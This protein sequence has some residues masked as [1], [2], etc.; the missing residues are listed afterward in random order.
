MTD[1]QSSK[2]LKHILHPG[3]GY[4]FAK[5]GDY[6]KVNIIVKDKKNT[7]LIKDEITY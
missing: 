4:S 5:N 2:V 1:K 7:L 3:N 6:A